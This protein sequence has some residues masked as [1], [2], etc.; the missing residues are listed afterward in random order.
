MNFESQIMNQILINNNIK[1]IDNI[2][3]IFKGT[4]NIELKNKDSGSG[5]FMKFLRNKKLFYCLVTNEHVIQ[6]S[7]VKNR[8]KI[9]IKYEN[10]TKEFS[11]ELNE[12]ERIIVCFGN[13]PI[14]IDVTVVQIIS[15]D[16]IDDSYFLSPCMNYYE[17]F[18]Y[19]QLMGRNIQIVQYPKGGE[20]SYSEGKILSLYP[21]NINIFFHNSDTEFGSSGGPIILK[22]EDKV[23]AIHKGVYMYKYENVGIF[24]GAVVDLL[25]N[26]KRNGVGIEYYEN[27][28]IKYNGFFSN[29]QYND[30]Q[31]I[32]YYTNGDYYIGEVKNGKK[33]GKGI[34]YYKNGNTKYEGNFLDDK[35][36]DNKGKFY[37]EN[38]EIFSGKFKNGQKNGYGCISKNNIIIKEG[39]F[40]ND[41]YISD[42]TTNDND[43]NKSNEFFKNAK[44]KTCHILYSLGKSFGAWCKV[45]KH[46][47]E[48]HIEVECGLWK[49]S[50]CPK[51]KNMCKAI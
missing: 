28:L 39:F 27:G 19:Y 6:Q 44:I 17:S 33:D 42:S 3:P 22:G 46:Y 14:N 13:Y 34:E 40:Q 43:I 48:N 25:R 10:K 31:G 51:E 4:V 9:M 32:F 16:K 47:V 35:Y 30:R 36:N 7:M 41:Q 15:K 12:K 5:F 37:Y 29:D 38:G 2:Y 23:L 11:L 24:I 26:Y 50:E 1:K 18:S 21:Q 49:C 8:D 45:C 20:L